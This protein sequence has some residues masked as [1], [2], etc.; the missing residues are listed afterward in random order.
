LLD[1][2]IGVCEVAAGEA[3]EGRDGVLEV[4]DFLVLGRLANISALG[5]EA[6]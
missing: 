5:A 4:G 1:L 3:D 6:Y 2:D